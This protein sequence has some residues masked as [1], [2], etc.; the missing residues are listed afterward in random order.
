MGCPRCLLVASS[1]LVASNWLVAGCSG[2]RRG[3][4]LLLPSPSAG[5]GRHLADVN[6]DDQLPPT[7]HSPDTGNHHIVIVHHHIASRPRFTKCLITK[8]LSDQ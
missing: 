4:P 2:F 3:H 1:L 5:I 8:C 6:I 7:S